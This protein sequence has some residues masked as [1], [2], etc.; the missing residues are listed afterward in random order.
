MTIS[1]IDGLVAAAKQRIVISHL[2]PLRVIAF[3]SIISHWVVAC[4][5]NNS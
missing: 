5:Y 2:I 4:G 1:T 3:I